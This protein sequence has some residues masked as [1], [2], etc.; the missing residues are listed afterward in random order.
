MATPPVRPGFS[1]IFLSSA[2]QLSAEEKQ[3]V[4][5]LASMPLDFI[6]TDKKVKELGQKI[7]DQA[8][9]THNEDTSKAKDVVI[10]ICNAIYSSCNDG[11]LRRECIK[12]A[13]NGIGDD[14]WHWKAFKSDSD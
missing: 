9:A 2:P 6:L 14:I 11:S 12:Q 7:F 3:Y 10:R 13:W 5:E 4:E 1:H 8:K